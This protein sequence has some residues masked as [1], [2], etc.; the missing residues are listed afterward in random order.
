MIQQK[1]FHLFKGNQIITL[2]RP[3]I[4]TAIDPPSDEYRRT[5]YYLFLFKIPEGVHYVK[6]HAS[7]NG[8]PTTLMSDEH[9]LSEAFD[10]ADVE[11]QKYVVAKRKELGPDVLPYGQVF[12]F[13]EVEPQRLLYYA[14]R[15]RLFDVLTSIQRSTDC[16]E[17]RDFLMPIRE[18]KGMLH[19]GTK[20]RNNGTALTAAFH[21]G[22]I[23]SSQSRRRAV[24]D[25]VKICRL[26]PCDP[27]SLRI[28]LCLT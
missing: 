19:R 8:I 23:G 15:R 21:P 18:V 12:E 5:E 2:G 14:V 13:K 11:L 28:L 9:L 10:A 26:T 4:L 17:L 22:E 27:V 1:R 25:S 16:D 7:F 3:F 6:N 24:T 20:G